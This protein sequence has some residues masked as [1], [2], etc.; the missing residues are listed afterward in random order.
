MEKIQR[1]LYLGRKEYYEKHLSIIN[2][3]LPTQLTV[4]EI[5]V[6]A[7]F[8]SLSEEITEDDVFNTLARKKVKKALKLSAGGLSN[9]LDA[10]IKK[11]FVNKSDITK[12]ITIKEYLIPDPIAQGYQFK[13]ILKNEE[14]KEERPKRDTTETSDTRR[15]EEL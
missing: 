13:I 4:K 11:G 12:R 10:L 2:P 15:V 9:Y 7:A 6:L 5:S 1:G 3:L 14:T 8:M